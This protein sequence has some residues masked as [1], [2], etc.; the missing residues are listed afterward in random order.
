MVDSIGWEALTHQALQEYFNYIKKQEDKLWVATFG[1]V[2]KYMRERQAATVREQNSKKGKTV[3]LTHSLDKTWYRY[4][5]S[6]RTYD[7]QVGTG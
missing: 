1:D 3:I 6:L 4:P 2:I 5:H 7:P